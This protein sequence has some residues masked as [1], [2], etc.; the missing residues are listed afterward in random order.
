M[1]THAAHS[2]A[3]S[4][5]PTSI[6]AAAPNARDCDKQHPRDRA[7]WPATSPAMPQC[8]AGLAQLVRLDDGANDRMGG[9]GLWSGPNCGRIVERVAESTYTH[10]FLRRNSDN[11]SSRRSSTASSLFSMLLASLIFNL[12]LLHEETGGEKRMMAR[13]NHEPFR[14]LETLSEIHRQTPASRIANVLSPDR[15]NTVSPSGT[16]TTIP[17]NDCPRL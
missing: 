4:P 15:S 9:M 8:C 11:T 2:S 14:N 16:L 6:C 5:E 10:S 3:E 13:S 17:C 7:A 1:E 12:F